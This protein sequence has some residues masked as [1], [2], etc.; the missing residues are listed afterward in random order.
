MLSAEKIKFKVLESSNV[1]RKKIGEIIVK[2]SDEEL[3]GNLIRFEQY[4]STEVPVANTLSIQIDDIVWEIIEYYRS[5]SL[6]RNDIF[7]IS[8][9]EKEI[10]TNIY[11]EANADMFNV[12]ASE[13]EALW[14]EKEKL[15]GEKAESLFGKILKNR[16]KSDSRVEEWK[17]RLETLNYNLQ[18]LNLLYNK[19]ILLHKADLCVEKAI[20]EPHNEAVYRQEWSDYQKGIDN[21]NYKATELVKELSLRKQYENLLEDEKFEKLLNLDKY[22]TKDFSE[23]MAQKVESIEKMSKKR[24]DNRAV[25]ENILEAYQSKK[26]RLSDNIRNEKEEDVFKSTIENRKFEKIK[27]MSDEVNSQFAKGSDKGKTTR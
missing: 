14:A 6:I 15:P 22:I 20:I 18:K 16:T 27:A 12:V 3:R 24:T 21:I 25:A 4:I 23:R 7:K 19:K 9:S 11:R 17:I 1:L 13:I 8:D 26:Y 10:L 5:N 2:T